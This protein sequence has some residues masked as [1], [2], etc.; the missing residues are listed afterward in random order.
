MNANTE[1]E[2]MYLRK[3]S[4]GTV[5]L[6]TYENLHPHIM[7]AQLRRFYELEVTLGMYPLPTFDVG[8]GSRSLQYGL[9]HV[10]SNQPNMS[11]ADYFRYAKRS[12]YINAYNQHLACEHNITECDHFTEFCN[13]NIPR[14]ILSID[15]TYYEGVL[16]T[17]CRKIANQPDHTL[18]CYLAFHVFDLEYPESDITVA[19][20][21]EGSY[22]IDVK[23][24]QVRMSV[25]G[26]GVE[27]VH[28]IHPLN[29]MYHNKTAI[30]Q[31]CFI[32]VVRRADFEHSAYIKVQVVKLDKPIEQANAQRFDSAPVNKRKE[33]MTILDTP[34]E[35]IDHYDASALENGK[36]LVVDKEGKKIIYKV[37]NATFQSCSIIYNDPTLLPQLVRRAHFK[38]LISVSNLNKIVRKFASLDRELKQEDIVN[39]YLT[40]LAGNDCDLDALDALV[41]E[42]TIQTKRLLTHAIAQFN[43]I[44]VSEI[45]AIKTHEYTTIN[46]N[47]FIYY[48]LPYY[49]Y[50]VIVNNKFRPSM[51]HRIAYYFQLW[52]IYDL[53]LS[54]FLS[55]KSLFIGYN[56]TIQTVTAINNPIPAIQNFIVE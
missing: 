42:A 46:G 12:Q 31:N 38:K 2:V 22:Q 17:I 40:G 49:L 25:I 10:F 21:L 41:A 5:I 11:T 6:N 35:I 37:T 23:L 33:E 54:Q 28:N 30:Y 39:A 20:H 29:D 18:I 1:E 9:T 43:S 8:A 56:K 4:N 27:Y 50:S 32:S 16:D 52:I 51:Q 48:L 3:I 47:R 7:L 19:D 24:N 45:N 14:I 44:N 15:S 53:F 36:Y 13:M 26:N 55:L 34:N